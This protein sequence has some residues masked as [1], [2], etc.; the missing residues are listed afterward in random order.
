[1]TKF[2]D[3]RKKHP[4]YDDLSDGELAYRL[5]NKFYSDVP[6]GLFAA[7]I[8]LDKAQ[9]K[10]M[11]K[12]AKDS[13]EELSFRGVSNDMPPLNKTRQAFQGLTFGAGDEIVAGGA[14]LIDKVTGKPGTLRDRFEAHHANEQMRLD[15]GRNA[16][17]ITS[18]LMEIGGALTIP[19]AAFK[20]TNSLGLNSL[21]SGLL[22]GLG[23]LMYG[24]NSGRGS[25]R[26][27]NAA[28]TG[29]LAGALGAAAPSVVAVGSKAL[30]RAG[31]G[32]AIKKAARSAPTKEQLASRASRLFNDADSVQLPR[33]GLLPMAAA[34]EKKIAPRGINSKLLPRTAAVMDELADVATD[35][36]ATMKF[37][38]LEDVRKLTKAPRG[39]FTN[40]AEQ[41]GGSIIKDSIDEFVENLDPK[42]GK[43]IKEARQMWAT[44]RKSDV[45]DEAIEKAANQA[46]GFENGLR[47]QFRALL[48][49]KKKRSQ[50][51]KAEIKAMQSVVKGTA[52]G[53]LLKRVGKL[54]FGRGQQ[55]NVLSGTAGVAAFGPLTPVA[56]QAALA[57]SEALTARRAGLLS[58]LVRAGGAPN[59]PQV[60]ATQKGII[61]SILRRPTRLV[62]PMQGL[63]PQLEQ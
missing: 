33:A 10:E 24:F 38:E 4:E 52:L 36:R 57:G 17:P 31:M 47:V 53:N 32:R 6:Y 15:Q 58:D 5:R 7:E 23:G 41:R 43:D 21:R 51:T 49:N 45:I 19:G 42:L 28:E 59:T 30:E 8:D 2:Q 37:G 12:F 35:P 39:D 1:M 9:R 13:G 14:A 62:E 20:S 29:I 18:G 56:G 26:A 16:A 60:S 34:A 25:Q 46:S 54:G 22:S 50:F 3:F 55:S 48:N 61:E 63:M 44:L 40:P 11:F 27:E